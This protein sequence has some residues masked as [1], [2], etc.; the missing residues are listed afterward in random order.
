MTVY[1]SDATKG[2]YS[3]EVLSK[4]NMPDDVIQIDDKQHK[5]ML[6][7]LNMNNKDIVISN[8]NNISY[9]DRKIIHTWDTIRAK[10][11]ALLKDSDHKVMPDYVSDKKAWTA[12][13]QQLRDIT[14]TFDSPEKVVWP[15]KPNDK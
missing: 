9:V 5:E 8:G 7:Q 10:R 11:N 3:D 12:Y 2:F 1:Y 4:E 13:R 6:Y 14:E 15:P